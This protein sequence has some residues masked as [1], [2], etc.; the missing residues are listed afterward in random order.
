[1]RAADFIIFGRMIVLVVH[2]MHGGLLSGCV[3]WEVQ[4][5]GGANDEEG[6]RRIN[7]LLR[8]GRRKSGGGQRLEE[9]AKD[10]EKGAVCR[11]VEEEQS[12]W[13]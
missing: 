3:G 8:R 6:W 4:E 12:V 9:E 2:G 1:M 7:E 11:H 10:G 5:E 13:E